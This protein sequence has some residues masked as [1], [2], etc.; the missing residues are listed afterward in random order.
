MAAATHQVAGYIFVKHISG[1]TYQVTFVN[2][3]NGDPHNIPSECGDPIDRDTMRI[4]YGDGKS[5]LLI[6]SN[7]PIDQN[8]F[9]GG[10]SVCPCRKVCIYTSPPH[11][12]PAGAT[13]Y[14]IW[15]YDPDRM[16]AINNIPGFG[17][18]SFYVFTSFV[19]GSNLLGDVSSPVLSNPLACQNACVGQCYSFNAGA[20]S[21]EGDSMVYSLGNCLY[22][23]LAD[24]PPPN[25]YFG[26]N[27]P[28]YYIPK[29]ATIDPHTGALEWCKP[30]TAGIYNFS[31]RIISYKH[32]TSSAGS[33]TTA[34]D[35][36]DVELEVNVSGSC[37]TQNPTI[38]GDSDICI[39]AGTLFN[40]Y[41]TANDAV[42]TP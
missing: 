3:V 16:Y 42:K 27:I 15:I 20:Y 23:P 4:Y 13:S 22:I 5:D 36:M 11:L 26:K 1:L 39:A 41:D 10:D 19:T 2:Y 31:I 8:D 18:V 12:Y 28:G 34:V 14:H 37:S 40:M 21:A 35:T 6:R 24:M 17:N 25:V 38:T 9:P 30:D 33:G 7:G 29:G 32:F